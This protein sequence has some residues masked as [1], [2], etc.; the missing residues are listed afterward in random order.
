MSIVKNPIIPISYEEHQ[1][2]HAEYHR[3]GSGDTAVLFVHGI[4]S[5]PAYF[6]SIYPLV[7]EN[8]HIESILLPGHGKQA[9]DF[10]RATIWEWQS[11]VNGRLDALRARFDNILLV[12]HSLGT[13]LLTCAAAQ[14]PDKIRRMF[15]FNSPVYIEVSPRMLPMTLRAA[16]ALQDANNPMDVEAARVFSVHGRMIPEAALFAGNNMALLPKSAQTRKAAK[17]LTVPVTLIHSA[18]DEVVSGK[19]AKF[20]RKAGTNVIILPN[21]SHYFY[22]ESDRPVLTKAFESFI[23]ASEM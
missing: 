11:Y 10:A 5:S 9:V 2:R 22:D 14:N 16:F 3:A 20:W 13:L 17:K 4:L 1:K 8:I 19:S 21:S 7:P 18:N 6:E 12:G 23:K 15:L